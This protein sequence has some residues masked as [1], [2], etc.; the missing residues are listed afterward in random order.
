[1]LMHRFSDTSSIFASDTAASVIVGMTPK[2]GAISR[3][4]AASS[5]PHPYMVSPISGTAPSASPSAPRW[6]DTAEEDE[7]ANDRERRRAVRA[8]ALWVTHP[9]Q[10]SVM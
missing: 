7:D 5:C 6:S 3:N 1:M 2:R 9:S 4:N 8:G 10:A